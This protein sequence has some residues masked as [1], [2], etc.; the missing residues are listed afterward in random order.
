MTEYFSSKISINSSRVNWS[1]DVSSLG[2][3]VNYHHPMRFTF[4]R[5]TSISMTKGSKPSK[6]W[7][8][9]FNHFPRDHNECTTDFN[10]HNLAL[11]WNRGES[12]QFRSRFHRAL[13]MLELPI[14]F[15]IFSR[16]SASTRIKLIT[17]LP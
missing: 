4:S 5:R 3:H 1:S 2:F 16:S 14:I 6:K 11:P 10:F 9:D 13:M 7:G 12:W 15:S 17:I 8:S